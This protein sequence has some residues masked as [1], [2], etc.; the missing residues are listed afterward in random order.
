MLARLFT[1][2]IDAQGVWARPL[3]DFNHRVLM[4]IYGPVRPLKDFLN[5]KWLGHPLHGAMT[6]LPIGIF[7]LVIVLD[8]LNLRQA[9]DVAL[10]I[11]ILAT[12][13]AAIAGF[14]DYTDTS[15][16]PRMVA[17]VHSALMTVALVIYIVSLVMR[18]GNPF[19]RT[20][21]IALS[22]V[23]F[24]LVSAGAYVGGEVVYTLGNMVNRHAWRFQGTPKWQPLDV[25]DIPEGVPTKAKAGAQSL[26]LVR[27]GET[28][29]ALHE[30]CAHAGG[31]LAEGKVVDG[32]IEC[33]W[34]G[35]RFELTTGYRKQGPTTFDQPRYEVRRSESGGWEALRATAGS[36]GPG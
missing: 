10:V 20:L 6:D 27:Q 24:L 3:G 19:D 5:G 18:L 33:P 4:A 1:R 32:C 7:L 23:G 17:T 13:G 12:V 36:A 28:V 9:A 22:I 16:R 14:A 21:P 11:G 30:V 8:L 26:V 29:H 15:G 35:S 25:T 31:P 34:H 2:L